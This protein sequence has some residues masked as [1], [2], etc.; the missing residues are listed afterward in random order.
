MRMDVNNFS[1]TYAPFA[2]CNLIACSVLQLPYTINIYE[3]NRTSIVIHTQSL[4]PNNTAEQNDPNIQ[5]NIL[6]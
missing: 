6:L 5:Y 3:K 2:T 4:H 1:E